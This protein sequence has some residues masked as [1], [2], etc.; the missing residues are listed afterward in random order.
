MAP[1]F[2]PPPH[3][4]FDDNRYHIHPQY[5]PFFLSF[6]YCHKRSARVYETHGAVVFR[7]EI[8][9]DRLPQKYRDHEYLFKLTG[10]SMRYHIS[11]YDYRLWCKNTKITT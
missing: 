2:C 8:L 5:Q 6:N 9:I 11:S 7:D 4:V 3:Y 10:T 1:E